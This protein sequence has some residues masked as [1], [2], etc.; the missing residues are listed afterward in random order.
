MVD[1]VEQFTALLSDITEAVHGTFD[2]MGLGGLRSAIVIAPAP[3]LA[4][5]EAYCISGSPELREGDGMAQMLAAA[6]MAYAKHTGG[7]A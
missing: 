6:P 2:E 7:S 1:T 4:D 5:P 3:H